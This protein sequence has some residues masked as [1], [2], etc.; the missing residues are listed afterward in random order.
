MDEL[1]KVFYVIQLLSIGEKREVFLEG[2]A[3]FESWLKDAKH[4]FYSSYKQTFG[5][6]NLVQVLIYLLIL[7]IRYIQLLQKGVLK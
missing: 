3:F 5:G 4:S 7:I 2:E 6:G 1:L